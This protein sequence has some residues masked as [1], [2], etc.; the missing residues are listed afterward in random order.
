MG[1]GKMVQGIFE[2]TEE[3]P[4]SIVIA[5]KTDQDEIA[6]SLADLVAQGVEVVKLY[7]ESG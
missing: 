7:A 3:P 1:N 4:E 2:R 5:S 6:K